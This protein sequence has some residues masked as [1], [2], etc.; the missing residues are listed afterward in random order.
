M[1]TNENIDNSGNMECDVYVKVGR[2]NEKRFY[3]R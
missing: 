3:S 1:K 2:G